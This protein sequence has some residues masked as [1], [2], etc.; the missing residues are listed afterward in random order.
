MPRI[1]A[2]FLL[3]IP[4]FAQTPA[5]PEP[6]QFFS[7]GAGVRGLGPSQVFG[8]Y[9][10]AQHIGTDTYTTQTT[11]LTRMKGGTVGTS[12]RAGIS[13]TLWKIGPAS[14]GL[15]GEAGVAEG[16]TGSATGAVSGKGFLA[17]RIST[18]PF[19]FLVTAQTLQVAGVGQQGTITLGIGYAL[20]K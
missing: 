19:H 10:I 8:Y 6:A 12:V 3:A 16:T 4:A 5:P 13:K 7:L 18:S 17:V 14:I 11:E 9:S 20:F 15:I 2:W 1:L